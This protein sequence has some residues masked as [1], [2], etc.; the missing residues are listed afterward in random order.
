M[1]DLRALV[2]TLLAEELAKLRGEMLAQPQTER[3]CVGSESELTEFARMVARRAQK[4]EFLEALEAGRIR[5]APE[6]AAPNPVAKSVSPVP[7]PMQPASQPMSIVSTMPPSVPELR[8][9]LVT[10]RDIAAIA[11][12]ETRLRVIRT[13]RFTPLAADEAR[14]RG[15]RIER[16]LA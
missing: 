16:T 8:K 2:R 11:Q 15:I 13:A 6:A 10:E 9:N 14:R 1:S 12:G 4:P 3:V 7:E 5:F